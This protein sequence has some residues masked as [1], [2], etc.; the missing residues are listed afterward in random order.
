MI[1]VTDINGTSNASTINITKTG[2]YY[3]DG[4]VWIPIESKSAISYG[5][6]KQG[7]QASDH[8]GWLKLDDRLVSSLTPSQ[9]ARAITLGFT[10]NIPNATGNVLMQNGSTLGSVCGTNNKTISRQ[11]LPN[12]NITTS[13]NGEHNHTYNDKGQ[14]GIGYVAARSSA[15]VAAEYNNESPRTTTSNGNHSHTFSLNGGVTQTTFDLTPKSL[16]V[17]T[18]LY[19]GE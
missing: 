9:Q 15:N 1:Y 3:F 11:N 7:F 16:S 14:V 19:L 6:T 18:F 10:S 12:V 13:T 17:N 5:D 8:N 4:S 2:F